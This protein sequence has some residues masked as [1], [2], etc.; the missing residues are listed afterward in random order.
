VVGL[1]DFFFADGMS[2]SWLGVADHA[3]VSNRASLAQ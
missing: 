3:A 1:L 2:Y